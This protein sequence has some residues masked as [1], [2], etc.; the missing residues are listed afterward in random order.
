MP[1]TGVLPVVRIEAMWS[2]N[3][4]GTPGRMIH[5]RIERFSSAAVISSRL[6][7]MGGAGGEANFEV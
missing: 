3:M 7:F 4:P 2:G 6:Q 1:V 5:G